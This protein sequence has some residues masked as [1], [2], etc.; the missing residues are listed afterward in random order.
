MAIIKKVKLKHHY[1]KI[2][3]RKRQ[4]RLKFNLQNNVKIK[5]TA[6]LSFSLNI[7]YVTRGFAGIKL[8]RSDFTNY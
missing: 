1:C 3:I 7:N 8:S 4:T 5:L 2:Y 6:K